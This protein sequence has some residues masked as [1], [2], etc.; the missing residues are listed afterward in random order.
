MVTEGLSREDVA[1]SVF[2]PKSYAVLH[3]RAV[4]ELMG[5]YREVQLVKPITGRFESVKISTI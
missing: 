5:D 1:S 3:R 2:Y 4:V